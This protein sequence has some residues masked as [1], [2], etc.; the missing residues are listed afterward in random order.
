MCRTG[1]TSSSAAAPTPPSSSSMP[2]GPTITSTLRMVTC[3][4]GSSTRCTWQEQRLS[5]VDGGDTGKP[6]RQFIFSVDLTWPFNWV[7]REYNQVIIIPLGEE[8]DEV[9]IQELPGLCWR[10]GTSMGRSL[11]IQRNQTG[12]FRRPQIRQAVVLPTR[13]RVHFLQVSVKETCAFSPTTKSRPE[14]EVQ[15]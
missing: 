11:L 12:S 2:S 10:P 6:R 13:P 9:S 1:P 15:W 7:L 5:P 4:P 14:N 3:C 8:E